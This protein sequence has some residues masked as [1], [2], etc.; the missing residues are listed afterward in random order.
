LLYLRQKQKILLPYI[1][2]DASAKQMETPKVL[3]EQIAK[4]TKLDKPTTASLQS[5][6]LNYKISPAW[7]HGGKYNGADCQ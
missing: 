6:L 2:A 3:K 1:K 5:I 7:Y 4:K